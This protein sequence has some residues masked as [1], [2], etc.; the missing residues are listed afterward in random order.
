[1][2]GHGIVSVFREN[3]QTLCGTGNVLMFSGCKHRLPELF[4]TCTS[5]CSKNI[6]RFTYGLSRLKGIC[7]I[8]GE[9][10]TRL[11]LVARDGEGLRLLLGPCSFTQRC[12]RSEEGHS[13]VFLVVGLQGQ[14]ADLLRAVTSM[15]KRRWV[16]WQSTRSK[17]A[18]SRSL[19][20][21]L[22][23]PSAASTVIIPGCSVLVPDRY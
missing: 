7:E 6:S 3:T 15:L 19:E 12:Y 18:P 1:M 11:A 23:Q 22:V 17:I 10:G 5:L 9:L 4:L 16:L 20:A 14:K 13:K 8:A 21:S 2:G